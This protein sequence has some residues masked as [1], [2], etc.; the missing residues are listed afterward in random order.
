MSTHIFGI[1]HHGPGSARSLIHA[2]QELEP[3]IV[4]VE[5]PP[6][7]NS[8][9]THFADHEMVMPVAMLV[10][11]P[12][13]PRLAAYYP[14]AEFSPEYQAIRYAIQRDVAVRFMDL[15][16]RYVMRIQKDALENDTSEID[17]PLPE[18]ADDPE[19]QLRS[20]PLGELARAAG[21]QDGERWWEHFIENQENNS[22]IFQGLL[23]AMT[24]LREQIDLVDTPLNQKRE[25]YMRRIIHEAER[26]GYQTIAVVC[27]AWHVPA[28]ANPPTRKHD[29]ELLKGLKR[30]KVDVTFTPWTHSRLTMWS[31][32]GAGIWSPGWY[33]HR[34]EC[35][36]Q[37]LAVR[38]MTRVAQLLRTED[39]EASPAQVIDAI[40][41]AEA[42]AAMRERAVPGLEEFNEAT[43]SVFC[44]GNSA[45]IRIIYNRLIVGER[46]GNVPATVPMMPL[47]HDLQAE[48]KRLRLKEQATASELVLDLREER[49]RVRSHLLHRLNILEINWGTKVDSKQSSG[50]FK[51]VWA[52]AW[53]PELTLKVI[54]KSIW[55]NTVYDAATAYTRELTQ[56][57]TDLPALTQ[58]VNDVL[59]SNLPDA[60]AH[61]VTRLQA[62]AS[63]SGNIQELMIALPALAEVLTYG[64]VRDTD[65]QMVRTVVDG[66]ITRTCIGLPN[67]CHQLDDEAARAMFQSIL[68]FN[69]AIYLLDQSAYTTRWHE[70]LQ[71]LAQQLQVHGI[72]RGRACRILLDTHAIALDEARRQMHLAMS[73]VSEPTDAAAWLEGFLYQSG[74]ILIHDTQLLNILD[75]W[76]VSLST[77]QFEHL[78][79]VLRRTVS[80]FEEPERQ[81]IGR[82]INGQ[83]PQPTHHTQI[84]SQRANAILPILSELLGTHPPEAE[85]E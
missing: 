22:D 75:Q 85:E 36:N 41:L 71:Q 60:V 48:Q 66:M 73:L 54:E 4:L 42:L 34:W 45:P 23:E 24:A 59:L 43:L 3:D 58:L 9:I 47:Q 72:I 29:R 52:L 1:R 16:Q 14:F 49:H 32:Y 18:P 19:Q 6:D 55:G 21:Y 64:N 62:E 78:L 67:A 30:I 70:V 81:Q 82:I 7:A 40:R 35:N 10:Y 74:L 68:Q 28:L 80:V 13:T 2:L 8:L 15:P 33:Q 79:P 76:V 51:E 77:E 12:D 38:W 53:H 83:T 27:G 69:H 31:G 56:R 57:L 65:G 50:T 44:Y 61:V 5:G 25:A 37:D 84:D 63:T 20:D 46:M 26:D 39:L 11:V 17:R